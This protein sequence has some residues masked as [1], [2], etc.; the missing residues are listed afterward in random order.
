MATQGFAYMRE[1]FGIL[2]CSMVTQGTNIVDV[3]GERSEM[4]LGFYSFNVLSQNHLLSFIQAKLQTRN[5]S[6][7]NLK[8]SEIQ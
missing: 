8:G 5:E 7:T 3:E 4:P 6:S 2:D 1:A